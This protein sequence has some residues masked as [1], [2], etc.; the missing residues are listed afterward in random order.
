MVVG[1][2]GS[3]TTA[4]NPAIAD[5][6]L[7]TILISGSVWKEGI[8]RALPIKCTLPP[9]LKGP[10]ISKI[11]TS[12]QIDVPASIPASSAGGKVSPT[13]CSSTTP[14]RCSTIM[15]LARPAQPDV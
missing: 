3:P 12:K 14:D 5:G 9:Q 4:A 10:N 7:P 13:Q 11:E 15:P 2:F 6:T 8:S 1:N